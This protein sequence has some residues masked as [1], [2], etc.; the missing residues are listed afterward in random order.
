MREEMPDFE[1][2][3]RLQD[4]FAEH[5]SLPSYAGIAELMDYGSKAAAYKLVTR[6]S[7]AGFLKKGPG[8]R[9]APTDQF[10]E[11]R[12]AGAV[13]AGLPDMLPEVECENVT[14]DD[15]LNRCW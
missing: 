1:R 11:R 12:L 7:D 3:A 13:R 8:R 6:L 2:L 9:L 4:F 10:F 5:R 15:Y 14:I